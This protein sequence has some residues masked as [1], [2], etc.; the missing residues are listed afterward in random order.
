M[1]KLPRLDVLA[2]LNSCR[3]NGEPDPE[4]GELNLDGVREGVD[5]ASNDRSSGVPEPERVRVRGDELASGA[6]EAPVSTS[7]SKLASAS[8]EWL[9][10]LVTETSEWPIERLAGSR[11]SLE[12]FDLNDSSKGA[13]SSFNCEGECGSGRGSKAVFGQEGQVEDTIE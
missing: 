13:S 7:P 6:K 2:G 10:K 9:S 12:R 11:E 4:R 3:W 1:V 8:R 5:R